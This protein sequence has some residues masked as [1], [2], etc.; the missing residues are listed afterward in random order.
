[1]IDVAKHTLKKIY[2]KSINLSNFQV[3]DLVL[4]KIESMKKNHIQYKGPH[5]IGKR[6]GVNSLLDLWL[7]DS[8]EK[9]FHNN[10][11]QLYK[12]KHV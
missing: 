6:L 9:P 12:T 5:Q 8:I 1:M 4:V 10:I 7:L 2:E 3:G 11:L